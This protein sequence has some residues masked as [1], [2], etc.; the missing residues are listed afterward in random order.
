MKKENGKTWKNNSPPSS[1]PSFFYSSIRISIPSSLSLYSYQLRDVVEARVRG[2][3]QNS[4]PTQKTDAL[5]L[6]GG[7]GRAAIFPLASAGDGVDGGG[8]PRDDDTAPTLAALLAGRG[9]CVNWL[10]A[11]VRRKKNARENKKRRSRGK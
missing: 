11:F 2:R 5:G 8:V 6:V 10:R 3:I 9:L 7:L 4:E 1:S